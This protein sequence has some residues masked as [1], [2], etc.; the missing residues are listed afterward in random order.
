MLFGIHDTDRADE[1]YGD[2]AIDVEIEGDLTDEE[3]EAVGDYYRRSPV[4]TL[5]T[6]AQPNS[7]TVEFAD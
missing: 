2:L 3:R 4:Y 6:L 7:P 5:M 1:M